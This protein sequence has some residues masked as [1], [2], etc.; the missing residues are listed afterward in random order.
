[1]ANDAP[2]PKTAAVISAAVAML[3]FQI[4]AT[5]AKQ[6]I[7]VIGAP[8]TTALRLGL[9][10]LLLLV[11]QRPW[12]TVPS[13]SAWPVVLAYGV[14]LGAMN[15]VF[16]LALRSIPLG[17]AVAIEFV[18]PL[19]VAILASRRRVDYLWVALAAV[20]LALL[21]PI[22][23]S[24]AAL[25]PG[26]VMYAFGAGIGWALYIVF[27]QKA[28]QAHG[29]SASTWGLMIAAL[30]TVPAGAADAAT[31]LIDPALLPLGIGVAVFSSALPYTLEM[32]ALR[33]LSA[34]VFG[35]LMS[36]EPAIAAL[37]AWVV[38]REQLTPTQWIAIAA[39]VSASAGA[40]AGEPR[41]P[42]TADALAPEA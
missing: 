9:S 25:D 1:V 40:V 13:R 28:G 36:F 19:S 27:G 17:V 23:P 20:G 15:W 8:G 26:G 2:Q 4:G 24:G 32:V 31:V 16:Y 30:V 10:A 11:L 41:R 18:G 39:I 38:L 37:A 35:T 3:S 33:R 5:F 6:L 29:S 22:T 34:R 21:L 42:M 7:P 12:R 14:S